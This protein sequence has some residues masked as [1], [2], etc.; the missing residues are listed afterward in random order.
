MLG[1]PENKYGN[2]M[3]IDVERYPRTSIRKPPTA[4]SYVRHTGEAQSSTAMGS[5]MLEDATT[6][7]A[8]ASMK[9][10]RTYQ[11]D[12]PEAPGGKREVQFDELA[13]GYEYGSTAVPISDSDWSVLKIETKAG[14][15]II[16]FIDSDQ[17]NSRTSGFPLSNNIKFPRQMEMSETSVILPAR[18]NTKAAMALSSFVRALFEQR[19]YAVARL[20]E[21]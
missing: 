9:T 18:G 12:D 14:L 19:S 11:V 1:D 10:N 15:E 20:V 2:T 5:D 16:G 6:G 13:K 4:S 7:D 17:V 3:F 21:R 8:L